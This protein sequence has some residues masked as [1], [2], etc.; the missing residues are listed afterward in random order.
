MNFST[1]APYSFTKL[2]NKNQINNYKQNKKYITE[3]WEQSDLL[4]KEWD[5]IA[6]KSDFK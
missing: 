2:H 3:L 5:L 4:H 1:E 6:E